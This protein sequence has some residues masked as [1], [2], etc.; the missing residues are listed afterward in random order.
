MLSTMGV[1]EL[2]PPALLTLSLTFDLQIVPS[3]A[4]STASFRSWLP[5]SSLAAAAIALK[6]TTSALTYF[7]LRLPAYSTR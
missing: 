2:P 7:D 4:R 3:W 1:A 5:S 6:R